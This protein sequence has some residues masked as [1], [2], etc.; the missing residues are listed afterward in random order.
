MLVLVFDTET[1]GL[2]KERDASIYDTEKWPH[3]VQISW[4]LYNTE[5]RTH[6]DIVD[7]LVQSP[8]APSAQSEKIHGISH[9]Q[10][11]RKGVK[12]D[13]ALHRFDKV[14][15]WADVIVGHNV[16]FDK[17]MVI[18]EGI[19]IGHKL[20]FNTEGGNIQEHCTMRNNVKFCKIERTGKNNNKYLKFPQLI[21]LYN[22]LFNDSPRMT[23]N[24]MV[25][26]LM[27]LRCYCEREHNFDITKCKGA[28]KKIYELYCWS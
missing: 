23:H 12:I 6:E 21:E 27:C 11:L 20:C 15:S 16:S 14:L 1:T 17:R 9:K 22:C 28:T 19:R 8:V 7:L 5:T 3:I 10:C 4:I 26:V 25:D 13:I 2:P 18:V 24:A